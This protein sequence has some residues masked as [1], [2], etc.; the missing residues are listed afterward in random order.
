M[1]YAS[2]YAAGLGRVVMTRRAQLRAFDDR[3]GVALGCAF[4]RGKLQNQSLNLRYWAKN[5]KESDQ[6]EQLQTAVQALLD[7]Q[8]QIDKLAADAR[9]DDI[10]A[11]LMAVE[12][13]AARQY[14]QTVRSLVPATYQWE[15]R[16]GRGASDP[17]IFF[18]LN[19]GYGILYGQVERSLVQAGLDPFAGFVHVDRPGK[20]S[21]TLDLIEEFLT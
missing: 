14:W 7:L 8:A 18:L 6:G 16:E 2:V 19:Y 5:R 10:R 11:Q 9:I 12:G 13:Q 4:A 20:P 17:V 21:L 3:R 15:R 1:P